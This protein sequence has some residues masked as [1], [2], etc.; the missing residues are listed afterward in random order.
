MRAPPVDVHGAE[1]KKL[2]RDAGLDAVGI[3]PAAPFL[4]TR[5]HLYERRAAGLHA[6]MQFTYRNP[7]RSTDPSRAV[8]GARSIVVGARAYTTRTRRQSATGP[9]GRVAAYARRD[10]YRA[11]TRSLGV[12]ADRLRALGWSALVLVD[13]NA[14]VDREA[15]YRAGLGWYGKNSNLLLPGRGSWFVLGSVV[16]N[17]PLEPDDAPQ[18]DGCGACRW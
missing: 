15:A 5:G 12:I 6:G 14:L 2:G 3:A 9:Q 4:E 7:D 16:T 8:E 11:L 13:D 18:A 1:L 17:A 10:H